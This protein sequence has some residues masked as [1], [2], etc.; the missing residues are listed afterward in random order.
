MAVIPRKNAP[1]LR[2]KGGRPVPGSVADPVEATDGVAASAMKSER[3][4][5]GI[6]GAPEGVGRAFGPF[7]KGSKAGPT[8]PH[9]PSGTS[10]R[11]RFSLSR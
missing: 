2:E 1:F 10:A 3:R 11:A 4:A 6:G 5:K 7:Q 9:A 8:L